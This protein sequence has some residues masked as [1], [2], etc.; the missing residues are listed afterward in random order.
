MS[1]LTKHDITAARAARYRRRMDLRLTSQEQAQGFVDDVGFCFLFPIQSIEMPSLW[2]AI[3]GRVVKTYS[4]H[5]GYEIERTWGWKDDALNKR[6]W[7]YGKLIRSRATLV[8][9]HF[10]SN[11]Y[12]LSENYGDTEH[13]YLEEYRA[14][15]LSAEAKAI[16]E[17]LLKNGALDAVR[18][19]REAHMI[20]EANKPRFEKALTELQAG[21][22][23]LPVGIAEAGAWRYAFIYEL[24]PRWLPDV[25]ERARSIGRGPAR[26]AILDQY[27][28][29]VIAATPQ[30]AARV[31]GWS[32]ADT[33]Q[34]AEALAKE[35]RLSLD[36]KVSGIAELQMVT[37]AI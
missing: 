9:L 14:G 7:Y 31:F 11:F 35:G 33:R 32:L 15:R 26:R 10:L 8:G 20:S 36:V 30:S 6:L 24:L 23:V 18:L 21:L 16:Y 1:N 12:A 2:D 28:R 22:K 5:S 29:N 4:S 13:D 27:I 3:A 34:A 17:A 25:P 37:H 19:R